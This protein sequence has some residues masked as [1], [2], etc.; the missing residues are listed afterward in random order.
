MSTHT[1]EIEL[2]DGWALR[3]DG[4]DEEKGF[5]P[6]HSPIQEWA[7]AQCPGCVGGWGDCNLWRDFAY[8]RQRSL[9]EGDLSLIRKGIC[10]RRTNGSIEI[11]NGVIQQFDMSNIAPVGSGDAFADAILAYWDKFGTNETS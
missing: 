1:H 10:P 2:P 11:V 7:N 6:E 9:S 5:C 3:Y 8:E 4:I